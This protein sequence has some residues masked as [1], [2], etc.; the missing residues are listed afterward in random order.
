MRNARVSTA[1]SADA[2]I[3]DV[4]EAIAEGMGVGAGN[5]REATA[6]A[7]LRRVGALFPE[8]HVAHGQASDALT[9]ICR[10][11]GLEWSIQA[12]CSRCCV[13]GGPS[14]AAPSS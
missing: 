1:F 3:A 6:D 4:I 8:G 7:E 12:A 14:S 13:A 11:A 2:A 10:S 5:A 9:A